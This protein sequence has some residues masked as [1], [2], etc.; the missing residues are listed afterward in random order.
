VTSKF[1]AD[2]SIAWRRHFGSFL[3]ATRSGLRRVRGGSWGVRRAG[4]AEVTVLNARTGATLPLG[5][6]RRRLPSAT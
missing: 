1:R 6:A 5:A 4:F 2:G 3:T